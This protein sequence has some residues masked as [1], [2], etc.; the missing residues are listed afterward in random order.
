M[1]LDAGGAMHGKQILA[2]ATEAPGQK[3]HPGAISAV[4]KAHAKLVLGSMF[5][6]VA[7]R[8]LPDPH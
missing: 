7:A 5:P 3:A 8:R 6:G 2:S 1:C 4:S